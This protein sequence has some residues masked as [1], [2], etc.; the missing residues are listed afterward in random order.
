[1]SISFK[2]LDNGTKSQIYLD[3]MYIGNVEI[4]LWNSKWNMKPAF[5]LPYNFEDVKK[6]QFDSCYKA[7]K[8][9]V[10]LYNFLFPVP[11]ED[12]YENSYWNLDDMISFLKHL[13]D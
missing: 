9:M 8:K 12:D 1:M 13:R 2:E 4:N 11:E 3:D 7:G 5:S 6:E 10:N